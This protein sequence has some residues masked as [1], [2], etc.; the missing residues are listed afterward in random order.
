[1]EQPASRY[2]GEGFDLCKKQIGRL[3]PEID[4]QDM[5]IDHELAQEEEDEEKGNQDNIPLS[6]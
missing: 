4:I 1:M 5:E 2:F 3:H 6:P